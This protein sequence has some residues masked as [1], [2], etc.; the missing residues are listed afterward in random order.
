MRKIIILFIA[1]QYFN[2]FMNCIYAQQLSFVP[3]QM[4]IKGDVVT[5]NNSIGY[6]TNKWF[7]NIKEGSIVLGAN[8]KSCNPRDWKGASASFKFHVQQQKFP[9]IG[10]LKISWMERDGKGLH[11]LYKDNNIIIQLDRQTIWSKKTE[12]LNSTNNDFYAAEHEPIQTTIVIKDTLLHIISFIIPE[13][14]AWDISSIELSFFDYPKN[15][16]GIGYSPYRDCQYHG[17]DKQPTIE[18]V[19]E[20]L[21]K[22]SHTCNIIRTYS[23]TGINAKVPAIA[24]SLGLK[25][26]AGA[27]V[28]GDSDDVKKDKEEIDS[29]IKLANTGDIDGI[30]VSNEYFQRHTIEPD[31]TNYILNYINQIKSEIKD[32]K[33]PI[34]IAECNLNLIRNNRKILDSIDG[35]LIHIYPFWG[36]LNIKDAYNNIINIHKDFKYLF[37]S[38]YHGQN[39]SVIIGETGW[40]SNG[41]IYGQAVPSYENQRKYLLD[42]LNL[43]DSCKMDYMYF[44]AYDEL[45]KT[46]E[47]IRGRNWGYCYSDRTSKY[48]FNGVLIPPNL[49]LRNNL[50]IPTY[51]NFNIVKQN[52]FNIASEWPNQISTKWPDN[53]K[54]IKLTFESINRIRKYYASESIFSVLKK[55]ENIEFNEEDA[56]CTKFDSLFGCYNNGNLKDS[57]DVSIGGNSGSAAKKYSKLEK[58]IL[59]YSLYHYYFP[60]YMGDINEIEMYDC[61]R[62]KP[63][64]GELSTSVSFSFN[65]KKRWCGIYWLP[66]YDFENDEKKEVVWKNL[67]G[68]NIYKNLQ[69]NSKE[70]IALTFFARGENGGEKVQ[71]KFEGVRKRINPIESKWLTLDKEWKQYSIDLSKADLSNVIGGFCCISSED[72]N[73]KRKEIH[74]FL[75]NIQYEPITINTLQSSNTHANI[76]ESDYH[77]F[78]FFGDVTYRYTNFYETKYDGVVFSNE[79]RLIIPRFNKFINLGFPLPEPYISGSLNYMKKIN[80]ENRLNYGVGIEWRPLNTITFLDKPI[81]SWAKQLRFYILYLYTS[82]LQYEDSWSWR[83]KSDFRYGIELYKETNFYNTDFYWAEIWADASWRK[84]NFFVKDYNSWTFAIVPKLG[85][86]ALQEKEFCIM[87]YV[88]GE[89]ALTQRTEFWQNRILAGG[90]IRVMPFRWNESKMHGLIKGLRIY[91][92]NLW[93][94]KYLG[95]KAA[96]TIPNYDLRVGINYTI[97]WQ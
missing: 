90:G 93:V 76:L 11:S 44:D 41:E 10:V 71:F 96:M 62:C 91:I 38:I 92:E 58:C 63:K 14:A 79:T 5:K 13:N 25:V 65:G 57:T 17:G 74:F 8:P 81:F 86:K 39:K 35:L 16:K 33:I 89:L 15:M 29:L 61:D 66:M 54:S 24:K 27:W 4:I 34:T 85:I 88:T 12:I 53:K 46:E 28:D 73:P 47:G 75:D 36:G 69:L 55:L 42:F 22:L 87:P 20:D 51:L 72:K 48:N 68:V 23:S 60:R 56:F 84:T 3:E 64:D 94:L 83:P 49:I 19:R 2:I 77:L 7:S 82:F 97:N 31:A 26:Y 30:I 6:C 67:P 43:A 52:T 21:I 1:I 78:Q 80:W 50:D 95:E 59:K 37:D 9:V 18:N 40:P 70:S 32:K 45:W